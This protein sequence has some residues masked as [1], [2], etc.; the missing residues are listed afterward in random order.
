MS[1]GRLVMIVAGLAAFA[2]NL[3]LLRSD[4]GV[5]LVAVAGAPIDAGAT[6]TADMLRLVEVAASEPTLSRL[7]RDPS[8]VAGMVA[9]VDIPAGDPISS[10]LLRD[11]AAT[12][13]LRAFTISVDPSH[14]GGGDLIDAGD[15]VDVIAV[16]DGTARYVVAAAPVLDVADSGER[17]LVAATDYYVV[18]A[19]DADTALAL[20]EAM[21]S[22]SVEV[23]RATGAERVPIPPSTD[24]GSGV[25]PS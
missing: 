14:A 2:L 16:D 5:T 24:H 19:V 18:V 21:Q 10:G 25:E 20:A 11:P 12:G 4:D 9:T 13:G 15:E 17:G 7:V 3:S 8:E 22:D 23:V 6:V 1:T